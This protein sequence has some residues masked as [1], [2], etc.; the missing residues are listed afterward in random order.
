[1]TVIRPASLDDVPAA[2]RLISAIDE[3]TVLTAEGMLHFVRTVPER[4]RRALWAAEVDGELVAWASAGLNWESDRDGDCSATLVVHPEHRRQGIGSAVWDRL[5]EHLGSIGAERVSVMGRDKA[6][7]HR[8]A[9]SR[10][11]RETGRVRMSRLDPTTLPPPPEPPDGVELRP[12]AA[13]ADDPRP[14]Y[15]LDLEVAPDE[16]HDLPIAH[17]EWEEWLERYWRHPMVDH[18]CSFVAVMDGVPASFTLL[19]VAPEIGRAMTGMTGTRRAFRGRGLAELVKRH[20][21]ARA[22]AKGVTAAFTENDET[23][24]PM[25]A[26]NER[27][28]YRPSTTRVT[29]LRP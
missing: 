24:V 2:S 7:T 3:D 27:L 25:L 17:F 12:F 21:L 29:F 14:V 18:D 4:A 16:P 13:F 5:E 1:V 15:E 23:N 20:S 19:T 9:A 10:G 11:F 26:V 6:D 28:G 22:T 8:F